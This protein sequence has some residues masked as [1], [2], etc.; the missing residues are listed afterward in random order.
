MPNDS[1][2][3]KELGL[4]IKSKIFY[5]YVFF[6][7]VYIAATLLIAP[8]KATLQQYHLTAT[9]LRLFDL[10]IIIPIVG[11]WFAAFYGYARLRTY[12][13]L[14]R[15]SK[16]GRHIA[17]LA[18]GI[19]ILVFGLP[20][21]SI[22]KLL[23]DYIAVHNK[24]FTAS[25]TIIDNYISL[26]IPLVAFFVISH[27]TRGLVALSKLRTSRLASHILT[28]FLIVTGV[29][30]GYFASRPY[31]HVGENY[32]LSVGWVLATLVIPYVYAW[33]LGILAAYEMHL[34]SRS[35]SGVLYRK[36]WDLFA[37]GFGSIIVVS[38]L[39]QYLTTVTIQLKSL[40]FSLILSLVYVLLLL[41][42]VGYILMA[43]G[44]KKLIKI[45]EV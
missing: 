12:T 20:I 39:I 29:L 9:S 32:H 33:F 2:Y 19:G 37:F 11:I 38:I 7:V 36:S 34:Y 15:R 4:K 27:G 23:L 21:S 8:P 10:T 40:R 16:D 14:V 35:V 13:E 5:W 26:V 6:A 28:I 1:V 22:S 18:S 24:G 43:V 45:E 30:Y 3:T 31:A 25:A 44:A 17:K 41:L 42:S